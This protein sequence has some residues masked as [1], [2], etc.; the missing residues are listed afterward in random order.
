M[1]R[2]NNKYCPNCSSFNTKK[3]GI[4]NGIQ[5]YSC[6]DCGR[7][8]R[9]ER[10]HKKFEKNTLWNEFVFHKQTVREIIERYNLDKKSVVKYLY[11][12]QIKKKVDH[13]PRLI[14]L[15]IDATYF[16]KRKNGNSWGVILFR[17]SERKENLWWKFVKHE[18]QLDY[19]E[20]KNFLESLGYK[21][22]SV[23]FD[24]FKGNINVFRGI[25]QQMCH[26][27]MKQIVIRNVTLK[28][29]TEPGQV[30]LAMVKELHRMKKDL[31]TKRLQEF[32]F[33][34]HEFLSEKTT[35]PDGTKSYTHE[36]VR[37][38]YNSLVFWYDYLFTYKS[39]T[40]IPNTTNTCDGHFS[41]LKDVVRIHRGMSNTLKQ[42]VIHSIFL[43]STIAP[44]HLNKKSL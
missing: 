42:K 31:F 15:V 16:L 29:K 39:N 33:R 18:S 32:H 22:A 2:N 3:R 40:H 21:I 8:F 11:D 6:N 36:G 26:F 38:A 43:E 4:E 12:F 7:R 35:H 14:Y 28:P 24:G 13:Q 17:D 1:S 34:Y 30:V 44:K 41:H 27:H 10:K 37:N 19:L 20:G 23:T 5:S 9:N 25:P